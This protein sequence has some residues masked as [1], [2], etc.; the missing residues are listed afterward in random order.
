MADLTLSGSPQPAV[1]AK[2]SPFP[3]AI[4]IP[5]LIILSI[6]TFGLFDFYWFYKQFKSFNVVRNWD[7]NPWW[8]AF[9]CGVTAFTLFR[10]VEHAEKEIDSNKVLHTSVLA[11]VFF[12]IAALYRLP[13]PYWLLA[14]LAFVPLMPVQNAINFYWD[15]TLGD[16][17]VKSKFGGWNYV[18][19]IVGL[20]VVAGSVY[21]TFAA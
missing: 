4:S 14:L 21:E 18:V 11:I 8:R 2:S 19:A 20:V 5:K 12:V 16:N 15:R 10:E 1:D 17:V 13:D 3:Y 7:I 6:A 9:F